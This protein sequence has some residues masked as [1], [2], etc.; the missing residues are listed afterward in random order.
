MILL[1]L[2]FE[3]V[4]YL[5]SG[6]VVENG[7]QRLENEYIHSTLD[8]ARKMIRH[9]LKDLD[10]TLWDWA[11]WDDTYAYVSSCNPAYVK[12][13]LVRA[14]FVD[15]SLTAIIIW[16]R[17]DEVVYARAVNPDGE[18]VPALS[19][20]LIRHCARQLP[21]IAEEQDGRGG[22]IALKE[23][24]ALVAKRPILT[25]SNQGPALGTMLMARIITPA[26]IQHVSA[27][28]GFPV[29]LLPLDAFLQPAKGQPSL[30]EDFRIQYAAHTADGTMLLFDIAEMPVARL[31]VTVQRHISRQS[32]IVSRYRYFI[33]MG[34]ILAFGMLG[35]LLLFR[36]VLARIEDVS[37]QAASV[38]RNGSLQ[39]RIQIGG[40]DEISQLSRDLNIM[41]DSIESYQH[42]I[43][44]KND[45]ISQNERF[46]NQLFNSISAGVILVEP[47]THR[48]V[49]IN[50]FA[51]KLTGHVKHEIIGRVCHELICPADRDSCPIL[52]LGQSRDKSKTELL[53]KNGETLPVMKSMTFIE[54][55]EQ[56][57]LLG[58]FVDITAIEESQ[59]EL[60]TAK[61]K[62]EQQ[63][64][65][66]TA[67]LRGIIDTANN[68][69]IVID[70]QGRVTEFSPAAEEIFGFCKEEIL[71]RSVNRLMP[72][73]FSHRHDQYID[74]YLKSGVANI[75]GKQ[76]E[77]YGKR[78]NGTLFPMD[79]ALN[80]SVVN[81]DK[82][83]VAVIR[84]VTDRKQMEEALAAG[85]KR[86]ETILETSPVGVGISVDGVMRF[87]NPSMM[88]M[89]GGVGENVIVAFV[90]SSE[91]EYI[92]RCIE[93][94]GRVQNY[95]TQLKGIDGG[96][97]DVMLTLYPF[98][99][100][101][102]KAILGWAVDITQRKAVEQAL[103]DA[104]VVAEEATKAKSDF[105]ANMSHEIRTPMNAI[106]GLSHMALQSHLND[107]QRDYIEKVHHS[108]E[109]LLGVLNDILDFSKIEAGKLDM[110]CIDFHLKD[111]LEHLANIVELKARKKGLN[112]MFDLPPDLPVTLK[113]D[114]LRLGQI[115]LN[116]GN[117]AVKFTNEGEI[118]FRLRI[119]ER[120][121]NEVMLHF[122]VRDSGIGM[123]KE[124]QKKLFRYFSQADT[125]I[126]R[127]Y[128]GTGLGL[129]IA[130]KLT[131]MMGG[132]IGVES[133]PGKG[134]T[135]YFTARFP[136]VPM[137]SVLPEAAMPGIVEKE[138][139]S[140]N[141]RQ[142]Q[143]NELTT[144][145]QGAR[146]LLVEDNDIN[147]DLVKDLL[148]NYSIEV[149]V[150]GNGR[151]ALDML[152][153]SSFDGILMDCQMPVMDGYTAAARIREQEKFKTLPIIAMTANVMAG[154][155]EKALKSGMNDHIG[156]PFKI[157]DMLRTLAGWIKPGRKLEALPENNTGENQG[158][159]CSA[160]PANLPG[161]D[162]RSG[163]AVV[164]GDVR[165]Y[166]Q[167]LDRFH[168]RY[169]D[170]EIRFHAAM[171]ESSPGKRRRAVRRAHS[172]KGV[173]GNIGAKALERAV[174]NLEAACRENRPEQEI[175]SLL[176]K[177][178][179]ALSPVLEGLQRMKIKEIPSVSRSTGSELSEEV[180]ALL[181]R[182]RELLEAS[183]TEV[184]AVFNHLRSFPELSIREKALQSLSAAIEACEFEDALKVLDT[185][186]QALRERNQ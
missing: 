34:M 165:L 96:I 131:E 151:R 10:R 45:A 172:L 39:K 38:A 138:K 158:S 5:V 135:F 72:E 161:I 112:L 94:N 24:W 53:K 145:L 111:V 17:Q 6:L 90:N 127:K 146:V 156:K 36:K 49:D 98:E 97:V 2:V 109:N 186:E 33:D 37:R 18:D 126:T 183:D 176:G 175:T 121:D 55:S 116:L 69:I 140:P 70:T 119:A 84:D 185:L 79:I 89:G 78:K 64:E 16:N 13:N 104:K 110:E 81:H 63:V 9:E 136:C 91:Q 20:M 11:S 12:S 40:H 46:L 102:Q 88:R 150:A 164:Q 44:K 162:I 85:K 129:A 149:E 117:N 152:E 47:E 107:K 60:E 74:K 14:T 80:E 143:L 122:C 23:Q 7:F 82:I 105:L 32:L 180:K 118:V 157:N 48:I 54:R 31:K 58:T 99:Y 134:S 65:E 113:G 4:H 27:L 8:S 166:R 137:P 83:F 42:E 155:V 3:T 169:Q 178:M 144:Q 43:L 179:D 95:E 163:I 35:Y 62:L 103:A 59:R 181:K 177:L 174:G 171:V 123:T 25:S 61:Q 108:A 167:L 132:E 56:R 100:H 128:G 1:L 139:Q 182:L 19:E 125:S 184:F 29:S 68:G 87:A 51:L 92:A 153:I 30:S 170:F 28:L 71:G 154:D 115:L 124:Q 147:R 57:F 101:G 173:A 114:P 50:A 76:V 77:I 22:I 86:L 160:L 168:N 106:I 73:P 142:K 67:R 41:L 26:M 148:T 141:S 159:A 75:M 93:E 21:L 130:K 133:E 66:R 52:D 120:T 15:Q